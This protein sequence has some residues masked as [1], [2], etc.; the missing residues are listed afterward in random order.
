MRA[1][2]SPPRR[3]RQGSCGRSRAFRGVIAAVAFTTLASCAESPK[4]N[5][6][7][8]GGSTS[9]IATVPYSAANRAPDARAVEW[10][11]IRLEQPGLP[12]TMAVQL[13]D[14]WVGLGTP[15]GG[16]GEP[17]PPVAVYRTSDLASWEPIATIH[18]LDG[19][20]NL[21]IYDVA[22]SGNHIVA[23]GVSGLGGAG[24]PAV[25]SSTDGGMNWLAADAGTG[26]SEKG[27]VSQVLSTTSGV[28][29]VG[30]SGPLR[31]TGVPTVWRSQGDGWSIS[32]GPEL[33]GASP[34][35]FASRGDQILGVAGSDA[36][37]VVLQVNGMDW[38][39]IRAD[40]LRES[41]RSGE[42]VALD[43][44]FVIVRLSYSDDPKFAFEV[45]RS[46]NGTHWERDRAQPD[47]KRVTAVAGWHDALI[48]ISSTYERADIQDCFQ[49]PAA[50]KASHYVS[51]VSQQRAP[52]QETNATAPIRKRS[53]DPETSRATVFKGRDLVI[54]GD[55]SAEG[56]RYIWAL[57]CDTT[58]EGPLIATTQSPA[59]TPAT[60]PGLAAVDA[61]S[62]TLEEGQPKRFEFIESFSMVGSY[63]GDGFEAPKRCVLPDFNDRT[64]Q[65]VGNPSGPPYAASWPIVEID[66]YWGT[67]RYV[68]ATISL[69][70]PD[71]IEITTDGTDERWAFE[72]LPNERRGCTNRPAVPS[73]E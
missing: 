38:E 11:R 16:V 23:G 72:P 63:K 2:P 42:L 19:T 48:A 20:D 68:Y 46:T 49:D 22:V 35:N 54:L 14:H 7:L 43:N 31:A 15:P 8:D 10:E 47:L 60:P 6:P 37:T 25:W 27:R 21:I 58:A 33:K 1:A 61:A 17:L 18:G 70:R 44:E 66:G 53:Q 62:L 4:A 13:D 9:S 24:R 71:R 12:V 40:G 57:L 73:G 39:T 50:C 51:L 36:G 52:L 41:G 55:E 29:L 30:E 65:I 64:W 3:A 67:A 59:T 26:A 45:W 28:V 56:E 34:A 32:R 69:V 5:A